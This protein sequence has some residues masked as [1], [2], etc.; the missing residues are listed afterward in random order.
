MTC[1]AAR[2]WITLPTAMNSAALNASSAAM[3]VLGMPDLPAD[4]RRRIST[5]AR[6]CCDPGQQGAA[7]R[8]PLA[9]QVLRRGGR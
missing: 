7:R 1:R 9:A 2:W 6:T 4:V 5:V 8:E 3:S